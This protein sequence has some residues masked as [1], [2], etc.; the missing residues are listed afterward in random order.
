[1]RRLRLRLRT[2]TDHWL[3]R[4]KDI[5]PSGLTVGL[6]EALMDPPVKPE[7]KRVQAVD[8]LLGS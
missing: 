1:M 3:V 6:S 7:G 8:E 5:P 4:S 2:W